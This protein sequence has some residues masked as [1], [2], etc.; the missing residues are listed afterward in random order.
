[1]LTNSPA[2]RTLSEILVEL[3]SSPARNEGDDDENDDDA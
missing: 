1:M 2:E 3:L